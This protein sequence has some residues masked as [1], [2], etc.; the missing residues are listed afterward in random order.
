MVDA[1]TD[2]QLLAD[3][4]GGDRSAFETLV[5]RYHQELYRF[6]L[7]FTNSSAAAEDVVQ[8]A[9]LQVHLAGSSFDLS[10]RLKPW[11]FTIAAN[12]ARDW[13]RARTRRHEVPLDAPIDA[14]DQGGESFGGILAGDDDPVGEALEAEEQRRVVQ[15]VVR[16]MPDHLREVLVLGYFHRFAYKEMAD[17]LE[18]PLGTVK[19]RLHAAVGHFARRYRAVAKVARAPDDVLEGELW[20]EV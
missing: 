2:E 12:K 8:E 1:P 13:L 6:A 5:R 11:L 10:R 3:Y 19:S 14:G 18:V 15:R 7:R 17:I 9:F 20:K 16:E 4:F